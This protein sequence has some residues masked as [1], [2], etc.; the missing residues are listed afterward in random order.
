MALQQDLGKIHFGVRPQAG[1]FTPSADIPLRILVLGNFSGQ[2]V[3]G[4]MNRA[5]PQDRQLHPIEVSRDNIE[6][7][8]GKLGAQCTASVG[9]QSDQVVSLRFGRLSDFHPDSLLDKVPLL[10]RLKELRVG[11]QHPTT[12]EKA[13]AE[14]R[15]WGIVSRETGSTADPQ[16]RKQAPSHRC[17]RTSARAAVCWIRPLC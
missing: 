15:T 17:R 8:P 12:Y 2:S 9:K 3:R 16:R 11:L 6:E 7:L 5:V 14:V 4:P 13:A 10:A 1:P